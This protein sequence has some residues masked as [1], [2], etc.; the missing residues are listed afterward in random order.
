MSDVLNPVQVEQ[1]IR[2]IA[3]R[4][5]GSVKVCSDRYREFMRADL[6]YDHAFAVAYMAHEGPAHEKKYA[7]EIAT[8][9][10][11]ELRDAADV[12][13]RHAERLSRALSDELRAMQSV[14]ASVRGMYSVAGRGES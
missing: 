3:N 7:A 6:E 13:Y 12:L 2:E 8:R 14:G 5:A 1:S 9:S 4:I 10:E 11:R